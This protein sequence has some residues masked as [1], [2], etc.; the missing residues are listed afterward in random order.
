MTWI[1]V[2]QLLAQ[3]SSPSGTSNPLLTPCSA[4]PHHLASKRQGTCSQPRLGP[5]S[6]TSLVKNKLMINHVAERKT[7]LVAGKVV[8]GML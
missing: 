5:S 8:V 2:S 7:Q 1:Q 3:G 6:N 4:V